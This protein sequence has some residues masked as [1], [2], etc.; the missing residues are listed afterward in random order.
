MSDHINKRITKLEEKVSH[1]E[2]LNTPGQHSPEAI[3]AQQNTKQNSESA[4]RQPALA[5]SGTSDRS[6][7][8]DDKRTNRRPWWR[9]MW[10]WKPWK[11]SLAVV[12][13]IAGIGYAII[14]YHL[15][16]DANANFRADQRAWIYVSKTT[17]LQE[18]TEQD[19]TVKISTSVIDGGKTPAFAVGLKHGVFLFDHDPPM[20]DWS[21][22]ILEPQGVLFPG[23]SNGSFVFS[24][25]FAGAS[26]VAIYKAKTGRIYLRTC[27]LYTDVFNEPHFTESCEFHIFGQPA[28]EWTGCNGNTVDGTR[29][30]GYNSVSSN[31][32]QPNNSNNTH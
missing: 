32:G 2:R 10:V 7:K 19:K 28:E 24:E 9:R 21:K 11:R 25:K 31:C 15:W 6:D 30:I 22:V 5:H 4:P 8:P 27:L 13:G 29:N 16:K 3:S 20:A 14:T 23:Q 17:M 18:P 1:L 26:D 12:V